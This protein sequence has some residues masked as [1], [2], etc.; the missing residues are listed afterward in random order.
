M[1]SWDQRPGY[2]HA[3]SLSKRLRNKRSRSRTTLLVPLLYGGCPKIRVTF[4]GVYY[5]DC[6]ILGS[7]FGFPYLGKLPYVQR[8]PRQGSVPRI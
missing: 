1:L 3:R 8:F 4:L 2:F 5:N 6:S 7:I